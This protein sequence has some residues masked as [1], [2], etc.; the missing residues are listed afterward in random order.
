[1][2]NLNQNQNIITII[3]NFESSE[4]VNIGSDINDNMITVINKFSEQI[5]IKSSLIV[6]LYNGK[7]LDNNDYNKPISEVINKSDKDSKQMNILA[8]RLESPI[9]LYDVI[10]IMLIFDSSN[11]LKLKGKKEETFKTIIQ[12][13]NPEVI[14]GVEKWNFYYHKKK[15][16]LERKFLEIADDYDKRVNGLTIN[17]FHKEKVII[18]FINKV[19]GDKRIMCYPEYKMAQ[20]I[21]GYCIENKLIIQ[22]YYFK[23]NNI[24][25]NLENTVKDLLDS[26]EQDKSNDNQNE[27]QNDFQCETKEFRELEIN[28]I[29]KN[30]CQKHK[31]KIISFIF[32]LLSATSI[33]IGV[34]L[35]KNNK[36][37]NNK[38]SS[39]SIFE[40]HNISNNDSIQISEKNYTRK[41]SILIS[42]SKYDFLDK[43]EISEI[44]PNTSLNKNLIFKIKKSCN[45]GYKLVN[46]ECRPEFCIKVIYITKQKERL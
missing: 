45:I 29:E 39:S 27:T 26:T 21:G 37:K 17:V 13:E 18:T 42:E 12:R 15:L 9:P 10:N 30:C 36:S 46:G 2:E 23:H 1:M 33:I 11:V 28:V 14:L 40:Y 41:E 22:F 34:I 35:G 44:Y 38:I 19:L 43:S 6:F 32:S 24:D 5:D 7:A 8:Y 16:D 3:F 25:I 4:L 20:V 31:L